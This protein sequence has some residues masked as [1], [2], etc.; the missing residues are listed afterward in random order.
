M[1][2]FKQLFYSLYSPKMM[3]RF[4]F[5]KLGKPILYVFLLMAIASVPVGILTTVTFTNAYGELKSHIKDVPDFELVEG[6]LSS[7]QDEPFI[8]KDNGDTFLFDTTGETKPDDIERYQ[9]VTAFLGDRMI[10]KDSGTVQEFSYNNFSTMSFTKQE[11]IE[12]SENLDDLLPIFIPLV[13]FVVYLLQTGLKFIGVT[14]LAT[15]GLLLK[16]I[17]QRKVSYKQ[18]W[19]LSAYAVTIPTLFF[20]IMSLLR[21]QVP[22]GFLLYWLVATMLLFMVIKEIPLPKKR[23]EETK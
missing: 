22:F 23:P 6:E 17:T 9:S 16:N 12:L 15:I 18:L 2:I 1:N 19:V 13:I 7:D 10:I 8:K 21:T 20:A 5:Q 11:V 4:R 14:V 3:A